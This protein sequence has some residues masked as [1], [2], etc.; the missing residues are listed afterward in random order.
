MTKFI[1]YVFVGM[2]NVILADNGLSIRT[3]QWWVINMCFIVGEY[4]VCH[5]DK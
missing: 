3:W 2:A 5:G 4:L 1:G